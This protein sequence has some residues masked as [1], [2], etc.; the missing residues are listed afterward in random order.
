MFGIANSN[1]LMRRSNDSLLDEV[2]PGTPRKRKLKPNES[3]I[4]IEKA[5][6]VLGALDASLGPLL[7]HGAVEAVNA[8]YRASGVALPPTTYVT[9]IKDDSW[10]RALVVAPPSAHGTPW[11]RKFAPASSGFGQ[12]EESLDG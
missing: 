7:T 12:S 6:R 5:Q 11:S 9:G 8:A 3:L 1:S 10:R 2:F 4:S